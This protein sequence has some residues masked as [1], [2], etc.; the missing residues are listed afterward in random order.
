MARLKY[1]WMS[2][3]DVKQ[4]LDSSS[5]ILQNGLPVLH[6]WGIGFGHINVTDTTGMQNLIDWLI[7][8][9]AGKYRVFLIGGVPYA[10]RTQGSNTRKEPE[11][12]TIFE[13]LDAIQPWHVGVYKNA[14][15]FD[16]FFNGTIANDVAYCKQK[17]IMYMPTMFPGF[18]CYSLK[19][20]R[21]EI[22]PINRIPRDGGR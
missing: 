9:A 19:R 21:N 20:Q 17:G 7:S 3:V 1:D 13:S 18:S 11:W 6:I 2:L 10:W 4:I 16:I 8:P 14:A 12:K 22:L 5:Y 15:D